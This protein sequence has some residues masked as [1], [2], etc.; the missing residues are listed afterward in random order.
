MCVYTCMSLIYTG[1]SFVAGYVLTT[2]TRLS[3]DLGLLR[4]DSCLRNLWVDSEL[5]SETMSTL[6]VKLTMVEIIQN[7]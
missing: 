3:R 1:S 6:T 5:D 7:N 4:S 2:Q